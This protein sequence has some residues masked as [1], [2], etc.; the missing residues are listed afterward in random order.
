MAGDSR[1]EIATGGAAALPPG[2]GVHRRP[3]GGRGL[4][5]PTL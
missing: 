2:A 5:S 4:A 3:P 1:V